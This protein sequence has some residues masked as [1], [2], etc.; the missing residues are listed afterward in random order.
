MRIDAA[1]V[2]VHASTIAALRRV[3]APITFLWPERGLLDGPPLYT[4][5]VVVTWL[6]GPPVLELSTVAD[7]TTTPWFWAPRGRPA[8]RR[9][10]STPSRHPDPGEPGTRAVGNAWL[11][12]F[13]GT[14][15][16]QS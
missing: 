16:E 8:S 10:S 11:S 3:S 5:D 2:L 9:P 12:Q 4:E 14:G 6:I 13:A 7:T 15:K 1:E